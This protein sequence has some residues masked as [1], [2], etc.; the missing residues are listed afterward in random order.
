MLVQRNLASLTHNLNLLQLKSLFYNFL[1]LITFTMKFEIKFTF[2]NK[3][4]LLLNSTIET[5]LII[6]T[7]KI[8]LFVVIITLLKNRKFEN[9]IRLSLQ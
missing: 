6:F 1:I 5:L 3:K 7:I 2:F 8:F 4:I 9:L